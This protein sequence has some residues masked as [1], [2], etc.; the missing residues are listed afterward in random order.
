[1]ELSP[2]CLQKKLK[3]GSRDDRGVW[4]LMWFIAVFNSKGGGWYFCF[5]FVL[6]FLYL[7]FFSLL[8]NFIRVLDVSSF[9]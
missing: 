9:L 1:M 3:F 2:L 7:L 5:D 6:Y 8:F 4:C